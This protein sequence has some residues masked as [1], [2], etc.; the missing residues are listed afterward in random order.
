MTQLKVSYS[1][2]FCPRSL[3]RTY[4][5]YT[6]KIQ[7]G[8]LYRPA[9]HW[10]LQR[11]N[12]V[13]LPSCP[14]AEIRTA[15]ETDKLTAWTRYNK[16]EPDYSRLWKW[17]LLLPPHIPGTSVKSIHS[18]VKFFG[19]RGHLKLQTWNHGLV[20]KA[21][22]GFSRRMFRPITDLSNISSVSMLSFHCFCPVTTLW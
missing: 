21:S 8:F 3:L 20:Y 1:C 17:C 12:R 16:T 15:T 6:S 5:T 2:F 19:N 14:A 11:S 22:E 9:N 7:Q 4:K 13:P 18:R 10:P